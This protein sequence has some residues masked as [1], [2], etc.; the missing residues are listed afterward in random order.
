[1]RGIF[2]SYYDETKPQAF[3]RHNRWIVEKSYLEDE[4]MVIEIRRR[5][6][7]DFFFHPDENFI[8]EIEKRAKG[9]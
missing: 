5:V 9:N 7:A 8:L 4:D 1:M 2:C 3:T 6:N